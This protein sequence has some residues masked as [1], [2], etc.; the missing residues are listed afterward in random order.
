MLKHFFQRSYR[1]LVESPNGEFWWHS[2]PLPDGNRISG[3]HEDKELQLSMWNAL[4]ISA[5]G[6]LDGKKVL[7]IGANDGFFSLAALA[8]GAV[9]VTSI[10]KD[11]KTWPSNITYATQT[12]QASPEV[13]TGDFRTLDLPGSYHVILFLG[14]LYHLEDVFG[15]TKRLRSLLVEG[16]TLYLE[17]QVTGIDSA[18]PMFEYASDIYPT[19]AP[20]GKQSLG[21]VGIS[22]YLFPNRQALFNLA[23]SYGFSCEP[24]D[25]PHNA[26]TEKNPLRH[27]YRMQKLADGQS[28]TIPRS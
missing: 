14:V 4:R 25:G 28:W 10:D 16:G 2:M 19:V 1:R 8:A 17:T 27:I 7:D 11:W 12:W 21:G 24:L 20:Q 22:N 3:A 26:Y 6:G 23:Y 15:C 13:V 18:L 9:S 5:D